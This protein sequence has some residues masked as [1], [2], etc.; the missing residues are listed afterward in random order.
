M[1]HR[2]ITCTFMAVM[3]LVAGSSEVTAGENLYKRMKKFFD[4]NFTGE[5]FLPAPY[6][7]D[8]RFAPRTIWL[9][10]ENAQKKPWKTGKTKAWVAF[11]DGRAVYSDD[12]VPIRRREI[13]T[14]AWDLDKDTKW[15]LTAALS[16]KLATE[17]AE[18]GLEA[19]RAKE[20]EV[21]ID[22]GS[23][24]IE[25]AFYYDMLMAQAING[26]NLGIMNQIL[27]D[28]FGDDIPDRRVILS[29]VRVKGGRVTVRSKTDV[30][31]SAEAKGKLGEVLGNLGLSYEKDKNVFKSLA[32]DEWKYVGYQAMMAD[33]ATGKI[34]TATRETVQSDFASPGENWAAEFATGPQ[35][36]SD[37][38]PQ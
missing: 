1:G 3:L 36:T 19:A 5:G 27:G 24:E 11:S 38:P 10:T 4:E 17:D 6:G 12:L 22:L 9:L 28:R 37:D 7:A 34:S 14:Q 21:D 13:S 35:E 8:D 16:G 31:L 29:A 23:V 32:I 20:L 30:D 25:Y 33:K 2:A 26:A 18:A 15:S